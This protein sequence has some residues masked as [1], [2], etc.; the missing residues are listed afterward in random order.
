[1]RNFA[2]KA[3]SG[4]FNGKTFH[5]VED[6]VIQGGDPVGN[7][8]GGGSIAGEYNQKPFMRGAVGVAS[9]AKGPPRSTTASG[10][11]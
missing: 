4:Y 2:N 8:S 5:R 9:T 10:L 3:R 11:W 7:G 1:M 6:W